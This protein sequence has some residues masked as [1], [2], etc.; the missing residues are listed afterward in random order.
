VRSQLRF[1]ISSLAVKMLEDSLGDRLVLGLRVHTVTLFSTYQPE[2]SPVG[3]MKRKGQELVAENVGGAFERHL[4]VGKMSC[5]P[6]VSAGLGLQRSFVHLPSLLDS[7]TTSV[8]NHRKPGSR[9][10]HAAA[11]GL[12]EPLC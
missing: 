1:H 11:L 2:I 7:H 6:K 12:C 9:G 5:F 8:R 3:K 10:V 4:S